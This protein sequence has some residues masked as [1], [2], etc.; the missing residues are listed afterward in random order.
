M[1]LRRDP[2]IAPRIMSIGLACLAAGTLSLRYLHSCLHVTANL[3]DGV[4]G[5]L[6]GLA[7]GLLLVSCLWR[8]PVRS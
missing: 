1:F 2:Q 6:Y 7:I 5:L 3:A 4:T 8:L